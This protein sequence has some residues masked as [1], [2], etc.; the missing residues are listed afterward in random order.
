M[1]PEQWEDFACFIEDRLNAD[2][3]RDPSKAY[4]PITASTL[5]DLARGYGEHL[6]EVANTEARRR[7][8]ARG[9]PHNIGGVDG[10]MKR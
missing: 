10:S 4:V 3:L 7:T 8:E 5:A 1:T 2:W 6:R 9:N